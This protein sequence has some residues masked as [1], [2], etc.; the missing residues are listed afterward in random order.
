LELQYKTA[1]QQAEFYEKLMGQEDKKLDREKK[2]SEINKNNAE[3]AMAGGL[4]GLNGAGTP[5][6]AG[7]P[8]TAAMAAYMAKKNGEPAKPPGEPAKPAATEGSVAPGVVAQ[9]LGG[10]T[11]RSRN[12]HKRRQAE[13]ARAEAARVE[14]ELEFIRRLG[15][16]SPEEVEAL[17]PE[18]RAEIFNQYGG[19]DR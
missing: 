15:I 8:D 2:Q 7:S 11:G 14:S 12:A 13:A 18:Q 19:K 6:A 1:T 16:M 10:N 3:T 5:G 4:V 9:G 17:S